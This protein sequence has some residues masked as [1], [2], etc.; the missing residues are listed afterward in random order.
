[1]VAK[2]AV[3]ISMA[4]VL[5]LPFL[6]RPKSAEIPPD[7]LTLVIITP[8]HEQIR[9][10]FD[11]GFSEW[12]EREYGRPVVI[13]WRQPGGT[14]EIRK[15]LFAQYTAAVQTGLISPDGECEPGVMS[16]DLLFGGGS[17]EHEQMKRGVAVRVGG[18]TARVSVSE[19]AGF[20][21]EQLDG[22][23]GENSLGGEQLYDPDQHWIG[24]ALSSFGIVYNTD[25]LDAIGVD[26]PRSWD[27]LTDPRYQGHLAMADPRASGS[28]ATAFQKILDGY[29]WDLGWRTLRALSANARYFSG[30]SR[31]PPL[32]VSAG[33]AAAGVAIDFYGRS[34]SDAI[35]AP[36]QA[37]EDSRVQYVD[38]AGAV[39]F[40]PDP[41]SPLRGG[42]HPE[43]AR[44]FIR[45]AL[46][47]EGQAIWQLPARGEDAEAIGPRESELRR[48]PALRGFYAEHFDRFIDAVNPY[49]LAQPLPDLGWRSMIGPMMGAFGIDNHTEL[50]H[51]WLAL[52]EVRES[53][54]EALASELGALFYAMP[55]HV[56]PDGTE[57]EFNAENYSTI[58]NEWRDA[59]TAARAKIR[60]TMF[61][62]RNYEE[63]VR[64]A[65]AAL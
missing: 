39:F 50:E 53:G 5:G 57:L 20:S 15:Q 36:G 6:F 65:K 56:M 19:A 4:V 3:A 54:D 24:V 17:Y 62:R 11:R 47:D 25:A 43:L 34:Q 59:E 9:A 33:E 10:E 40:D 8:H 21:P 37:P 32:D 22:W 55:T 16:Y 7:A 2:L 48:L 49:E 64:R 38:P 18:E 35:L 60:Y 61:F 31:R 1:M 28:V 29:G 42:P 14:S 45:F 12:H 44:R 30:S 13:D 46:T 63:I 58:R 52:N 23:F 41:I 51:A 27:D 26:P